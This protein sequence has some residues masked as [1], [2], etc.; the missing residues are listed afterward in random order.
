MKGVNYQRLNNNKTRFCD[1]RSVKLTL[2]IL[3]LP[4]TL[5]VLFLGNNYSINTH[6]FKPLNYTLI[7]K[8]EAPLSQKNLIFIGDVHGS[9]DE[10]LNLINKINYD[11]L[12]DHLIFVGDIVAKGPK[13]I[14]VVQ[15]IRSLGAS[16]VRGNHDDKVLQI[17]NILDFLDS[18]KIPLD[19][20][21]KEHDIPKDIVKSEHGLLA[22]EL[23]VEL[24]NYLLSCPII[25]DI[26]EYDLYVV[27]AGLL[28][29]VP[30]FEQDP[31][32][33]MSMRNIKNGKPTSKKDVGHAWS[34]H[35]NAAQQESSSPKT[36]IYGHDASRRLKI[37]PYSFGLDSG[38]VYGGE[39]SA[40]IW[41]DNREIINVKCN[42]YVD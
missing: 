3:I 10:L 8:L 7:N 19:E 36:I 22:K 34:K 4:L 18:Q 20:F 21:I 30:L 37:K 42:K 26:P 31:S 14:E 41:N 38:C 39:L 13:S 11:P 1:L 5:C 40:L 35:W 15:L 33:I 32:D 27:H 16:C 17:K 24:Y 2:L 9:Y 25:L 6:N 29:D 23:D 28:P 12:K